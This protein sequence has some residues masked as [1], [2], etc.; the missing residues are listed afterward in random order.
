M[1]PFEHWI[2]ALKLDGRDGH[3]VGYDLIH[4]MWIYQ[5][6]IFLIEHVR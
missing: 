5:Y 1:L 2:S 4:R 3:V 6:N